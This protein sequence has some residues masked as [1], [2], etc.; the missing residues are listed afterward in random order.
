MTARAGKRRSVLQIQD[1]AV[2]PR[3]DIGQM[4]AAASFVFARAGFG[5]SNLVKLLFANLYGADSVPLDR[6]RDGNGAQSARSSSTPTASTTGRTKG[7]P[8][9]VRRS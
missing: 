4:V 8:R 6:R 1:P 2:L 7:T 3:F 9:T 5:K